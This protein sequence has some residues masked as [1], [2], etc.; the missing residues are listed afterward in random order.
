MG[1]ELILRENLFANKTF[2]ATGY[3]INWRI[4]SSDLGIALA[5]NLAHC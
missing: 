2:D 1:L 3:D 5:D 4:L